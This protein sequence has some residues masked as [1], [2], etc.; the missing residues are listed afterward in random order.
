MNFRVDEPNISR[1]IKQNDSI[2]K[3]AGSEHKNASKIR[4]SVK[5]NILFDQLK[6]VF[7]DAGA[8]RH[9]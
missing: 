6:N 4:Q 3:A 2:L 1:W 9:S 7:G 5:Y 8:E